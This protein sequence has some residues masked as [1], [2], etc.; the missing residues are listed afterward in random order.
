MKRTKFPKPKILK[1]LNLIKKIAYGFS[2]TSGI[3]FEDLFQQACLEWINAEPKWDKSKSKITT[4]MWNT[5]T[6]SLINYV[7]KY[8]KYKRPL[9]PL[10]KRKDEEVYYSSYTDRLSPGAQVI[11]EIIVIAPQNFVFLNRDEITT[12]IEKIMENKG[13]KPT[14]IK[15]CI[16]ELENVI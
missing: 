6:N 14:K 9:E 12:Q 2:K 16:C 15:E 13:W 8:N 1:H 4:Y 11:A 3:E 10:E 7:D 5:L